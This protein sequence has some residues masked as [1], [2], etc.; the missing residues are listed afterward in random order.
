MK[1]VYSRAWKRIKN[2]RAVISRLPYLQTF[3]VL[4]AFA[5][6]VT[7][8]YF[9]V[10]DIERKHLQRDIESAISYTEAN[11]KAD[12]LEPE[13]ILAG[14]SET[15][16]NM[17]LTGADAK[18]VNKYIQNINNYVQNNE[19]KRLLGVHGF[20]GFFDVYGGV[21][22][23][24]DLNWKPSDDYDMQNRPFYTVAVEANGDIGVTPPY[25]NVAIERETITFV[26]RIFNEVNQPLGIICLNIFID[27]VKQL[28]INTQFVEKGYGFLLNQN[29]ELIAH[30]E[31]SMLGMQLR[32]VK[33]Y[34]A[35]YED[36]LKQ[37]GYIYEI[38]TTD[39][40]GIK[41]IVFIQR[42]YNGW[43]MGVVTPRAEYY[44]STRN[45][46]M[47]LIVLGMVLATILI[48]ILGRISMEKDKADERMRIMFN[49]MPL[50]ANIHDDDF[51]YFECNDSALNLFGLSSKKEYL[52]KFHQLSPEYQPD[53]VLSSER[54]AQV[55]AKVLADGY[56]RF[57]WTHQ[58]LKGEQIPCEI[59]LV[60]VKF[61][62]EFH[63]AGYI[64]DLREIKEAD[65][66]VHIMFDATPLGANFWNNDYQVIDCNWE[67]VRLFDMPNKQAYLDKFFDLSPEYQPDGSVSAKKS[68]E[69]VKGAFEEG[70]KRF[71]WMH[72]KLSG[73]QIPCE[74]TLIRVKYK[75]GYIVIGYTRDLREQ[76]AMLEEIHKENEK[77]RAMAHWYNSI[78]NS[79]PL[80]ISV[81][82]SDAKWTFINTAVEK[83]LGITLKNAVG[84]PCS[85][86]GSIICNTKDCG[87]A[88][89]KKGITQTYFS[90]KNLSFQVDTAILKDLKGDTI[91]YI[92]IVQDITNLKL[93]A[94]KQADAEAASRA[95]SAFLAR[96][97][98]E[99]RTPMNAILGITE[100]QLQDE[101][102]PPNIK[103]AF[104]EIY[105]SSDLLIS[106][107][108]D[109]LDLSKIEADKMELNIAKYE[110]ASLINDIA[111]I[112]MMRSSKFVEF[113][114]EVDE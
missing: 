68:I 27:R 30:P 52:E 79:I 2:L 1:R 105:N 67:T 112:N 18:T 69:Y 108:N 40:R 23:S 13:T 97:S 5:L 9:F 90:D 37:K 73:E 33:S 39:Y 4:I 94:K 93:M 10:S 109:I 28:A 64:R 47:F 83:F 8:S 20:Y 75:E 35:A 15:I 56:M 100:I 87:I 3:F 55:D 31:P 82:D 77:S 95:K 98:H 12:M 21:F 36:K 53:G 76:K 96:V 63:I 78:L 113:E 26:R 58:N 24:G 49:A 110:T 16:R 99:I 80:P 45:M 25:F 92:E 65:E 6:M 43:Y 71:E 48:I 85:N 84:K 81:T 54:M 111:H 57:E 61:G 50:G 42:L 103:E 70:Y 89:V 38:T 101:S 102:I 86:W 17:I 62:E 32:D 74:V 46:A 72:Q 60:R 106:I 66:R 19:E 88:C 11:I 51:S 7:V 59:I 29:M 91:G 34:I 104:S 22:L 114:L 41:S 107:I 14:I 44:K